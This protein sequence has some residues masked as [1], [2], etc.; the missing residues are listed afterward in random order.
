MRSLALLLLGTSAF[1]CTTFRGVWSADNDTA[2]PL[3]PFA[4]NGKVGYIDQRGTVVLPPQFLYGGEFHDGLRST[5]AWGGEYIDRN[6]KRPFNDTFERGWDFTEGLAAAM[7]EGGELW[8]YINTRGEWAIAPTFRTSPHGYVHPFSDGLAAIEVGDLVGYI[9]RSGQFT[10]QPRFIAGWAFREGF[11]RVI[12]DGPCFY[13]TDGGCSEI[14]FVPRS[15]DRKRARSCTFS[16]IDKGG[17][18]ITPHRFER[19]QDFGDDLAAVRI[20]GRWGYIDGTGAVVIEPQFEDA[21]RFSEGLALVK[22]K[23]GS[24]YIQRDGKVVITGRWERAG[25]FSNGLAA[26]G[27]D[28]AG[29]HYIDKTGRQQFDRKF[30]FAGRFFKG[31]AHVKLFDTPQGRYAYIDTEGRI[32]FTHEGWV[33]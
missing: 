26:V 12:L 6:G 27:T 18:I 19:A 13:A 9:D 24:A 20:D 3:Y 7:P 16:F 17:R 29:Y 30:R 8:G 14:S 25:E 10:I 11:A 32:V 22:T 21:G 33:P 1:A 5:N 31:L 15:A 2:D 23:A 4:K 28:D